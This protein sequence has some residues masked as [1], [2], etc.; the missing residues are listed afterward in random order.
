MDAKSSGPPT[1]CKGVP[2]S[3][4]GSNASDCNASDSEVGV[5]FLGTEAFVDPIGCFVGHIVLRSCEGRSCA[6]KPTGAAHNFVALWT[7]STLT[8][9]VC[10]YFFREPTRERLLDGD[11]FAYRSM[12]RTSTRTDSWH[13]DSPRRH[14]CLATETGT[15]AFLA[16]GG[17]SASFHQQCG[18][19]SC[20]MFPLQNLSWVDLVRE[21][22]SQLR[23]TESLR[24]SRT[25]V[26]SVCLVSAG[27]G[28]LQ[29]DIA[30][31]RYSLSAVV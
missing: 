5:T 24:R 19:H 10:R 14:S 13:S 26:S 16:S 29:L 15:M 23:S 6:A 17:A 7:G 3:P 9:M 25:A 18:G 11:A 22:K 27:R 8:V 30:H 21:K 4:L 12:W 20:C 28:R 2:S 31:R 1:L